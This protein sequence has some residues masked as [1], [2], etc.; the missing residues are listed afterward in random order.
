MT[1]TVPLLPSAWTQNETVVA[2]VKTFSDM[3]PLPVA[4]E[5][6]ETNSLLGSVLVM[7]SLSPAGAGAVKLIVA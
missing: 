5:E 3:L 6:G 7:V 2:P 1:C 4:S